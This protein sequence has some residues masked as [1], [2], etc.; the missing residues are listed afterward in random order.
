MR[1]LSAAPSPRLLPRRPQLRAVREGRVVVVD[2]D[3]MF[4]RPGPRLV[5]ALE[6]LVGLLH[7]RPEAIPAGFPY[8]RWAPAGAE[9]AAPVTAAGAAAAP[10]AAA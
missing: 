9:P 4:N 2:G 7:G 6:F 10:G 1:K 5:E 8:E 3:H